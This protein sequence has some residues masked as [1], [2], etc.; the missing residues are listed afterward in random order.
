MLPKLPP[1]SFYGERRKSHQIADLILTESVYSPHFSI[2]SHSHESAF[3]LLVLQGTCTETSETRARTCDS[4]VL[5]FHPAGERHRAVWDQA[6]GRCFNLEFVPH[7]IDRFSEQKVRLDQPADFDGGLSAWLA[8]RLYQEL[9]QMDDVS[10]LVMEGLA[11]ELVAA[12]TRQRE[13]VTKHQPPRWLEQARELLHAHFAD[14]LSLSAVAASVGVHPAHLA[15]VFRQQYR[16]SV[17]DYLRRLRIEFACRQL[18]AS[19]K[20][21]SEIALAAGFADQSHFSKTF[22]SLKGVPPSEY[23]RNFR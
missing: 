3:F 18:A 14:T 22:K 13:K 12:T 11:L 10:S 9:H 23:Q 6:G 4:S 2:P 16:C 5:V 19:D 8:L 20:S 15:R 21:L 17:G 7:W 1:G